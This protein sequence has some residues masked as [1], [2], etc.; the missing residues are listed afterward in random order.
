MVLVK[1]KQR[2]TLLVNTTFELRAL[3][4]FSAFSVAPF[5]ITASSYSMEN[6]PVTFRRASLDRMATEI[7][8]PPIPEV[9]V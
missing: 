1:S 5:S 3:N 6:L 7:S 8:V 2:P 9:L 4:S